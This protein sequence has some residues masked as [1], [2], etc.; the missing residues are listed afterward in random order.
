MITRGSVRSECVRS[1]LLCQK[2]GFTTLVRNA[3]PYLDAE[4]NAV[5]TDYLS[6]AEQHEWL[7]FLDD[8]T[9][10]N[11]EDLLKL[12]TTPHKIVTGVYVSLTPKGYYPIV[13]KDA[14]SGAS[15][16]T[17]TNVHAAELAAMERDEHGCVEVAACGA[18]MLAIHRDVWSLMSARFPW[19][20]QWFAEEVVDGQLMGEDFMFCV[21][22]RSIGIPIMCNP[23]VRGVHVKTIALT[24]D[25]AMAQ[26]L[27]SQ[28]PS[29]V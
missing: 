16:R 26:P 27:P 15:Q 11:P 28:E 20:T 24:W 12:T 21:R 9:E 4:R 10:V 13:Y 5:V 22:A 17:F 14:F 25:H 1:L 8:D 19:P 7:V 23:D 6:L 29:N 3:G 2:A 18:G